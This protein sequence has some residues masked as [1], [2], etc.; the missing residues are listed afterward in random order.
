MAD[1]IGWSIR[2]VVDKGNYHVSPTDLQTDLIAL[3]KTLQK[4]AKYWE[5]NEKDR[6]EGRAGTLLSLAINKFIDSIKVNIT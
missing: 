2:Q 1:K 3:M 5:N 6:R 4:L